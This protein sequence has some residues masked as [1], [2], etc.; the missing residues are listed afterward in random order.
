MSDGPTKPIVAID[1]P[2][3]AGKSTIARLLAQRLGYTYIDTGAMYRSVALLAR[4]GGV[5]YDDPA[6]L[7]HLTA[8]LE[9]HFV[10]DGDRPRL[11]VNGEDVS[12]L[13]RTPEMSHGSSQVS[14]WPG[15]REA[16]V[17][18]QRRLAAE[19]G[20]VMEGRDIG[21]VVFPHAN[22]KIFLTATPEERARRRT[23]ELA[24]RGETADLQVVLR[25]VVER[26]RCDCEREH[27]PLRQAEDAVEF[28]TDGL[29]IPE[30]VERLE[31][32]VRS[33]ETG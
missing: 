22:A 11:E 26:D 20:V 9:F 30:V 13:I 15:V 28:I 3:G 5:S 10:P 7:A 12:T 21:T 27:S 18:Q 2:A 31:T 24:G 1:G 29:T 19:G 32:L 23:A 6:G 4:R 16:L 14:R 25:D 33:R 8:E 17:R